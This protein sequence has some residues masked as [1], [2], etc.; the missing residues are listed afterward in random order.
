MK[1]LLNNDCS[2]I[3]VKEHQGSQGWNGSLQRACATH[4]DEIIC[5]NNDWLVKPEESWSQWLAA[6][7]PQIHYPVFPVNTLKNS[8]RKLINIFCHMTS[9]L[10]F[11]SLQWY[12]TKLFTF[13]GCWRQTSLLKILPKFW[14]TFQNRFVNIMLPF[15]T[16]STLKRC[17]TTWINFSS[18]SLYFDHITYAPTW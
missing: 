12:A 2:N 1:L 6:C 7:A 13:F 8:M 18:K 10:T 5:S 9:I 17:K 16:G 11:S 14:Q 15:S 4:T 3:K